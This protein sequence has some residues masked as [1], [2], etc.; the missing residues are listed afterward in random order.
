MIKVAVSALLFLTALALVGGNILSFNKLETAIV[1]DF[2]GVIAKI[3][4]SKAIKGFVKNKNKC[5]F[6]KKLFKRKKHL[7]VEEAFVDKNGNISIDD[8]RTLNPYVID[9]DVI[10][11]IR[12]LKAKGYP[13]FLCSNIGEKMF[14]VYKNQ[15]PDL[16]GPNGLFCDCWVSSK[17]NGYINKKDPKAFESCKSMIQDWA[18]TN[19]KTLINFIMVDDDTRHLDV[20][21]YAGFKGYSFKDAKKFRRDFFNILIK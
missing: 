16:F 6:F 20:A 15:R 11:V 14:E 10:K 1:F 12:D 9:E 17:D 3:S 4:S 5:K 7:S 19:A 2:H 8:V 13:V 18:S 21:S